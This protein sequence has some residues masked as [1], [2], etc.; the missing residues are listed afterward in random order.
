M[1]HIVTSFDPI[2]FLLSLTIYILTLLSF[3]FSY[4]SKPKHNH[5][6][7]IA[8]KLVHGRPHKLN[9]SWYCNVVGH[10]SPRDEVWA[11]MN[12]VEEAKYAVP[13]KWVHD[14]VTRYNP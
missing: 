9:A 10:Y 12:H 3:S 11:A 7:N 6:D 13:P 5:T 4:K 8:A 2:F 1:Y 14:D